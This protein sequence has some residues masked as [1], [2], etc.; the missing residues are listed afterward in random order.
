[1]LNDRRMREERKQLIYFHVCVR[2]HIKIRDTLDLATKSSKYYQQRPILVARHDFTNVKARRLSNA[3]RC[4]LCLEDVRER[5]RRE[6]KVSSIRRKCLDA[7]PLDEHLSNQLA[8]LTRV[9]FYKDFIK[10]KTILN[11][12]SLKYDLC[13]MLVGLSLGIIH[14]FITD[15]RDR[16]HDY[17]LNMH[18]AHSFPK[19]PLENAS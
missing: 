18:A 4:W 13:R 11:L 9:I 17:L 2:L 8:S 1:M 14:L 16:N 3:Q 15:S 6:D 10:I 12:I 7:L 5:C 19:V